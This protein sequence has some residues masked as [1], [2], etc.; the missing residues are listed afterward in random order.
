MTTSTTPQIHL[1]LHAGSAYDPSHVWW[2]GGR[3]YC[4]VHLDLDGLGWACL[5]GAPTALREL[6]A[7]LIESADH[8]DATYP[9]PPDLAATDG[10]G[11]AP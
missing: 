6:A 5:L 7:A 3:V 8:A 10:L 2:D 1:L 9:A 11:A 4:S